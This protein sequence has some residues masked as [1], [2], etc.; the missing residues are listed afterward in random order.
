LSRR[1]KPG[2]ITWRDPF[3]FRVEHYTDGDAVDREF[4][5]GKFAG[6]ADETTQWGMDPTP[7]F[8]E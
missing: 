3:G 7:E 8:F 1:R 2:C 4:Q 5:P 6:R